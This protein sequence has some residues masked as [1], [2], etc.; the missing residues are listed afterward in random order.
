VSSA[1]TAI[2]GEIAARLAIEDG[3]ALIIDYGREGGTGDT[4]QALRAHAYDDPLLH[5]GE[6]DITAHVD[7]AAL[8]EAA[9]AAGSHPR[10]LTTQGDFLRRLGLRERAERLSAGKPEA[11]RETIATAA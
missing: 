10:P 11:V 3:A 5:P 4:L 2:A 8:A 7:F 6:A 1:A 9:R